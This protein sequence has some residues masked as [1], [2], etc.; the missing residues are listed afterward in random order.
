MPSGQAEGKT[1]DDLTREE[2]A[3]V[4]GISV[5][6]VDR[7]HHQWGMPGAK[8]GPRFVRFDLDR[9]R[10]WLAALNRTPPAGETAKDRK[11][12]ERNHRAAEAR[13]RAWEL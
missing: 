9:V 6:T 2:L 3:D 4:L 10:A 12:R 8:L 13:N 5:T 11:A 1:V 7:W